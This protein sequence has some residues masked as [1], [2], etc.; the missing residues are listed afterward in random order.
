MRRIGLLALFVFLAA[1]P[2]GKAQAAGSITGIVVDPAGAIFPKVAITL[3]G[4]AGR[5]QTET[6]ASGQ[7]RLENIPAGVYSLRAA[8][9]GF[10]PAVL[11]NVEVS[12]GKTRTLHTIRLHLAQRRDSVSVVARE[13]TEK[14]P[15]GSSH[16]VLTDED[17][18]AIPLAG[19]DVVDAVSVMT[20]VVDLDAGRPGPIPESVAQIYIAGGQAASKN[21]TVDGVRVMDPGPGRT[22]QTTP[23]LR[24]V[25]EVRVVTSSYLAEYGRNSAGAISLVTR[26]GTRQFRASADWMW[27][28]ESLNANDFFNNRNG[29]SRLRNRAHYANWTLGGPIYIPRRWNQKRS[30]A[31]FFFSEEFQSQLVSYQSRTV[32]VPTPLEV[33]GDFSQSYDVSGRVFTVYD[34]QN[35]QRPFPGQIIPASRISAVGQNILKLFPPPNFVDPMPSRIYQWNYAAS[36]TTPYPRRTEIARLDFTLRKN[37]Q[38]YARISHTADEQHPP[39]GLWVN[40]SANFP[41]TPIHFEQPGRGATVHV[42]WTVSKTWLHSF[43]AGVGQDWRRFWP[44]N[45]ERVSRKATGIH[46][47]QWNPDLNP[48]GIIPNMTFGGVPNY[49]NPSIGNGVP[50][51]SANAMFTFVDNWTILKGKHT[52]KTGTYAERSRR[53]ET[54]PVATRGMLSFDR[55]RNNPLDTNYAWANALLGVFTSYSEATASPVGQ[56]RFTNLEFYAQDAWRV[57]SNLSLDFGMRFYHDMPLSDRR[58]QIAAF[59]P[60][61]YDPARA[62][63]L[64][65]PGY[66]RTGKK[67]AIDPLTGGW[68]PEALVG[69]FVPGVGDPADG[70]RVGGVG[71]FPPGLYTLPSLSLA[72]RFGFAWDPL[73]T[74]RTVIRGGFGVYYDRI[75]TLSALSALSNPPTVFTPLVYYGTLSGLAATA[76]SRVYAPAASLTSLGGRNHMPVTCSFSFGIQRQFGK[77]VLA[78]VTYMGN[79]SR[80]LLWQRNINPVAPGANHVD[81]HPENRDPTAPTRPLPRNFLRPY[82]GYGDIFMYEFASTASYNSLQANVTRRMSHGVQISAGYTF[83]KTLGSASGEYYPVSPFFPPRS[84]NYGPLLWDL[85]HVLT[86]RYVWTLPKPGKRWGWGPLRRVTDG[87]ETSALARFSTGAPFTPSFTTTDGQDITGTPS[88]AAR[89]D[90]VRPDAEPAKRFGRPARG[91]FGNTGAGI[92]RGKGVNNWDMSLWRQFKIREGKFLQLRCESYNTFNHTQFSS[93]MP[94]ARFDLQGNQVD[95]LF[96]QPAAA[97]YPRRIQVAAR[98][99]W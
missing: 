16:G 85:N 2:A 74:A 29:L 35:G 36:P 33:Q 40:G 8:A 39:F 82:V 55:D 87:W 95:P 28:H 78:D 63:V 62:P 12:F 59:D 3:F 19:R 18:G 71:G 37:L 1:P 14:P 27:R 66:D 10:Q 98:L 7:F 24:S 99:T 6:D 44:E 15:L 64:L 9:P 70:M 52:F 81:L 13:E 93:L 89:V 41:L 21:F 25:G 76:G 84:R 42:A 97:R 61:S 30:K 20:G 67:G 4:P 46:V 69:S 23:S 83:S 91:S 56:F 58:R 48:A 90:L 72:P 31:F 38:L 73:K 32:R 96:L 77:L 79:V 92:L 86:L 53:G 22:L 65:R 75:S 51:T 60:G 26:S 50:Y 68:Y 80:H 94:T 49:A 54:A 57:R 17:L 43:I 47:P 45:S 88:E 5:F 34:P 11:E